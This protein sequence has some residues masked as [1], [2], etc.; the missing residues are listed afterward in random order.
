MSDVRAMIKISIHGDPAIVLSRIQTFCS[1]TGG[2][3]FLP[4]GQGRFRIRKALLGPLQLIFTG[5]IASADKASTGVGGSD[6][7]LGILD[8]RF[9]PAWVEKRQLR[10][11]ETRLRNYFGSGSI[12]GGAGQIADPGLVALLDRAQRHRRLLPE[13]LL[14]L[15][16]AIVADRRLSRAEMETV[17][18]INEVLAHKSPEWEQFFINALFLYFAGSNRVLTTAEERQLLEW[19]HND[20]TIDARTELHLMIHMVRRFESVSPAFN[21]HI[22]DLLRQHILTSDRPLF[23]DAPRIPGVIG[24]DDVLAL[25]RVILGVG[26]AGGVG[27]AQTEA[28]FL[29]DLDAA[30]EGQAHHPDWTD[31]YTQSLLLYLETEPE[32]EAAAQWLAGKLHPPQRLTACQQAFLRSLAARGLAVPV[33][34]Q[35]YQRVAEE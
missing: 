23:T 33:A 5:L 18:Q 25:R 16:R 17:C 10:A 32:T 34:L 15:K 13:D 12:V 11:L 6:L 8:A 2:Y 28:A 7:L 24:A 4:D 26:S 14:E 31:F 9:V 35:Q 3:T 19:V 20:H 1:K 29:M 30:T 22:L 27:V 21:R